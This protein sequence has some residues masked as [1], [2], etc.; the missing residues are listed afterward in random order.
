MLTKKTQDSLHFKIANIHG[1]MPQGLEGYK[2][3]YILIK[4]MNDAILIM[5][6]RIL[7]KSRFPLCDHFV[8]FLIRWF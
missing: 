1:K 8:Y 2:I 3:K 5:R 7:Y 4:F 6:K